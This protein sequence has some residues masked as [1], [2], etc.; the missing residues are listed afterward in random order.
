M[1]MRTM[2]GWMELR[3][4]ASRFSQI[5]MKGLQ[6]GAEY[7][8]SDPAEQFRLGR[9][10]LECIAF[11]RSLLERRRG[12]KWSEQEQLRKMEQQVNSVVSGLKKN[13]SENNQKELS[14]ISK[15]VKEF[16]RQRKNMR[17]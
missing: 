13:E 6:D 15:E 1:P 5:L 10:A 4:A 9:V 8:D 7:R 11:R 16:W 2:S 17:K 12:P 3:K 14:R